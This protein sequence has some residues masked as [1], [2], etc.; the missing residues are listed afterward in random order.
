MRNYEEWENGVNYF[1][2]QFQKL[3]DFLIVAV[4]PA[5]EICFHRLHKSNK[6]LR[7]IASEMNDINMYIS[8]N[9][10]AYRVI[11]RSYKKILIV[12]PRGGSLY[13]NLF[14]F[15]NLIKV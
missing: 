9:F 12:V 11:L 7:T 1:M 4:T 6:P 5:L 8:I 10:N 14:E 15:F 13:E 2:Y 3:Y